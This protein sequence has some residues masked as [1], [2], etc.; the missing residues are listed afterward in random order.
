MMTVRSALSLLAA[1][2]VLGAVA[3][4]AAALEIG[5]AGTRLVGHHRHRR[6]RSPACRISARP[7]SW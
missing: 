5:E 1:V 3:A 2:V 6:Q 4:R 7:R